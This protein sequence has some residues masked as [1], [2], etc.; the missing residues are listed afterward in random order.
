MNQEMRTAGGIKFD[1]LSAVRAKLDSICAEGHISEG[2]KDYVNDLLLIDFCSWKARMF[3][4]QRL[5]DGAF[6]SLAQA[7]RTIDSIYG[8]RAKSINPKGDIR[9]FFNKVPPY[10]QALIDIAKNR[11]DEA[12]SNVKKIL[13]GQA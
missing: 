1:Q 3:A 5:D 4:E 8:G 6:K 10:Q 2:L 12:V 11:Y 7:R 9:S 13:G